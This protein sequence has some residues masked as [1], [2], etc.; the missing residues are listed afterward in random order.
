M[1]VLEPNNGYTVYYLKGCP[2][3]EGAVKMLDEHRIEYTRVVMSI[4]KLKQ[5]FGKFPRYIDLV[6]DTW[7]YNHA[8]KGWVFSKQYYGNRYQLS[9][10]THSRYRIEYKKGT[11]LHFYKD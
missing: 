9:K 10:R 11:I 7:I 2:Y 3:S 4:P 1:D 5:K 6:E 8:I